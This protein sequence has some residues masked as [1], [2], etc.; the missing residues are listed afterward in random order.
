M[1]AQLRGLKPSSEL[2]SRVLDYRT[3][4]L[5]KHL[6]RDPLT[7]YVTDLVRCSLK[8]EYEITHPKLLYVRVSS[9][10]TF[11]GEMV[12][13]GLERVLKELFGDSVKIEEEGTEKSREVEVDGV[14]YA[15]KGRVDAVLNGDTGIEIKETVSHGT[16]PYQ[17]HVEQC[18]LYNWLYGFK[19]T[20]LLYITPEGFYEFEV[21]ASATD[22]EVARRIKEQKAPR[23]K[24]ECKL[25]EFN[26]ICSTA[27]TAENKENTAS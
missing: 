18:A 11:L 9:G 2:V 5:E 10:R 1:M 8:R 26:T 24:W 22:E 12:H 14:R 17:H 6:P 27:K 15:V 21:T 25:C 23:Y 19:R 4:E 16:L 13:K 7:F 3:R 20:L